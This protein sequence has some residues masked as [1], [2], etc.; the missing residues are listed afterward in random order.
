ES[1]CEKLNFTR[2][3][4]AAVALAAVVLA[5]ADS[6]W[7]RSGRVP[8]TGGT[9]LALALLWV[10]MAAFA[11]AIAPRRAWTHALA[12]GCVLIGWP[13][14]FET[15]RTTIVCG[16][17]AGP[18]D[19]PLAFFVGAPFLALIATI[20]TPIPFV[21]IAA[22][23]AG[24]AGLQRLTPRP[25]AAW[26]LAVASISIPAVWLLSFALLRLLGVHYS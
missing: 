10:A 11:A 7:A 25:L 20:W 3:L 18:W 12:I 21:A 15:A 13:V 9:Y 14:A 5:I 4:R 24:A 16:G 26:R 23:A 6:A 19:L 2:I 22:V 17:P 8:V 1:Y